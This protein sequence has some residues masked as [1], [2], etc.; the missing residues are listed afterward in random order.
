MQGTYKN[1]I[2]PFPV[3]EKFQQNWVKNPIELKQ[4]NSTKLNSTIQ[5]ELSTIEFQLVLGDFF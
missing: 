2:I 3:F 1:N 4:Q 5:F